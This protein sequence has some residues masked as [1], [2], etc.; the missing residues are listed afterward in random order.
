MSPVSKSQG[1]VTCKWLRAHSRL[2]LYLLYQSLFSSWVVED[3]RHCPVRSQWVELVSKVNIAQL[4]A[5]VFFHLSPY[6]FLSLYNSKSSAGEGEKG[7][8]NS[9]TSTCCA[10]NPLSG[11][12]GLG[13][14]R[15][16]MCMKSPL[17]LDACSTFPHWPRHIWASSRCSG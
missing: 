2:W 1:S 9:F 15:C 16:L 12:M 8:V 11:V 4:L 13:C 7:T 3:V 17:V 6:L 14:V 10:L 5:L